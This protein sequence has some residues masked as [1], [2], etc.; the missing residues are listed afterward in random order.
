MTETRA[1]IFEQRGRGQLR[2]QVVQSLVQVL[3]TKAVKAIG[4]LMPTFELKMWR[5]LMVNSCMS[6]VKSC[7]LV[8]NSSGGMVV[9]FCAFAGL[10][11]MLHVGS[12]LEWASVVCK[13]AE[14]RKKS[15]RKEKRNSVLAPNS[16]KADW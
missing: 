6:K 3:L 10:V 15:T 11:A 14:A 2:S 5:T 8:W 12:G 1:P 7:A 9:D 13:S 16:Q 4:L